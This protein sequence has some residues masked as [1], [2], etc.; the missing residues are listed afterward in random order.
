MSGKGQSRPD[1]LPPVKLKGGGGWGGHSA[2][3][4]FRAGK[5]TRLHRDHPSQE[6]QGERTSALGALLRN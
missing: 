1:V 3:L 2:G 6:Q 4:S 5:E